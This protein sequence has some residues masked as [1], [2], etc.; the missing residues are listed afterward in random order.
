MSNVV[1]LAAARVSREV[2]LQRNEHVIRTYRD[3]ITD[4]CGHDLACEITA[5]RLNIPE[6][7]VRNIVCDAQGMF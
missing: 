4:W 6:R 7:I 1:S 3:E 5:E 2:L